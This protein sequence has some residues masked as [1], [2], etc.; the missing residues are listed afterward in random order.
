MQKIS[1]SQ[2][3]RTI[4]YVLTKILL[5]KKKK[6]IKWGSDLWHFWLVVSWYHRYNCNVVK[7]QKTGNI[8]KSLAYWPWSV[9]MELGNLCL[10][11][12]L[13]TTWKVLRSWNILWCL[14]TCRCTFMMTSVMMTMMILKVMIMMMLF[15]ALGIPMPLRKVAILISPT[16]TISKEPDGVFPHQNFIKIIP[17]HNLSQPLSGS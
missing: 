14:M 6:K 5:L 9:T 8:Y 2:L 7:F 1:P 12:T 10:V 16:I 15:P 11:R 13:T 4:V 3:Q 17:Q